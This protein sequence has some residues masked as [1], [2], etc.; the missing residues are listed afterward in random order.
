MIVLLALFNDVPIMVIAYD[1]V[2]YSNKPEEW[3]MRIVLG[4]ASLLGLVGVIAS[5]IIYYTG[6][7]I[8]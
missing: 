2:R 5:F 3:N 7:V 8:L 4:V 1:N 6:V